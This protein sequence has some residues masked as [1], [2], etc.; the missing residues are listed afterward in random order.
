MLCKI[1]LRLRFHVNEF[2][3]VLGIGFPIIHDTP[4][5]KMP[6]GGCPTAAWTDLM[7]SR[8]LA[9]ADVAEIDLLVTFP[10]KEHLSA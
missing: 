3:T 1:G 4:S 2:P 6:V 8:A 5:R 10:G 9:A 7:T